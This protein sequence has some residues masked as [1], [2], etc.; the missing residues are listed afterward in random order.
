MQ[1]QIKGSL[2]IIIAILLVFAVSG[3]AGQSANKKVT[4]TTAVASNQELETKLEFS[5]VLLPNQTVDISSKIA[6]QVIALGSKV[7][8]PVKAGEVLMKLDTESL[9]GQL[10][11]AE[12]SLQSAQ[13]AAQSAEIQASISKTNLNTAQINYNRAKTLFESGAV[14]KSQLDD[15]QD[16]LNIATQQYAN[17]AGPAQAQGAATINTALASIRNFN[18]QI[19]NA[20][21]KS[22]LNGIITN[23]NINLGQVVS[24]GVTLISMVDTSILKMKSTVT[25]DKLPT[26]SIG[27]KMSIIIDSY[28]DRIFKGTITSIGPI[29]VST[30]EVFPVEISMQNEMGL[31]AGLSAHTSLINR[32]K[33]IIVP[34]SSIIQS[35]GESHVFVIKNDIAARRLVKIG[36]RNDNETQ[37]LEG[38]NAGERVAINNVSVLADKMPVNVQ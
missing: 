1:K 27:Q 15:A 5:G 20:T 34:T 33:G 24:P 18:M 4:V 12:A 31:M 11:Q 21:I 7:G 19:N 10:M 17:A 23:Q 32:T 38:L 13:A 3:C 25:Q 22:P 30:G 2:L 8:S 29:A 36:I 37:I 9:N 16:K 28:P 35:N 14:A 26:L 6:G